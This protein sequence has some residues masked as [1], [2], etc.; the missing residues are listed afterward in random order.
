MTDTDKTI[1]ITVTEVDA[2]GAAQDKS[3]PPVPKVKA[4]DLGL[5]PEQ[6]EALIKS[7]QRTT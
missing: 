2:S 3:G 5:K 4:S 1:K 6:I 7:K